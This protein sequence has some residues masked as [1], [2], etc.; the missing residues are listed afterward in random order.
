M[1]S[2][3]DA[4]SAGVLHEYLYWESGLYDHRRRAGAALSPLWRDIDLQKKIWKFQA[5]FHE[6]TGV[7]L[8]AH[9]PNNPQGGDT[10][11]SQDTAQSCDCQRAAPPSAACLS[12]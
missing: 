2:T 8:Q 6:H 12:A 4:N 11:V 9:I 7:S 1:A 5:G 10:R 3:R